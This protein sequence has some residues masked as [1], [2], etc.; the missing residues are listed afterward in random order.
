MVQP[1]LDETEKNSSVRHCNSP[2][3]LEAKKLTTLTAPRFSIE[4][5]W[6]AA[7]STPRLDQKKTP[8]PRCRSFFLRGTASYDDFVAGAPGPFL[9]QPL[10]PPFARRSA[11]SFCRA[12]NLVR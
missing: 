11:I 1:D 10:R 2:E 7:K 4:P 3:E 8:T 9:S 5:S 6:I 12:S